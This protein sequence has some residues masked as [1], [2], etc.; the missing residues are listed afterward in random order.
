MPTSRIRSPNT[1]D[2]FINLTPDSRSVQTHSFDYA[3]P[4]PR[5]I[6]PPCIGSRSH[7]LLP[8]LRTF[9][10][11]DTIT[12]ADLTWRHPEDYTDQTTILTA[13]TVTH[14]HFCPFTCH[15]GHDEEHV[16]L[17][18]LWEYRDWFRRRYRPP[19][20]ATARNRVVAAF[21]GRTITQPEPQNEPPP[22]QRF[23]FTFV[24]DGWVERNNGSPPT[25]ESTDEVGTTSH[26]TRG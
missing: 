22:S 4:L 8:N 26:L 14:Y 13:L 3:V 16:L 12:V 21:R 1:T 24:L 9:L 2:P 11:N 5:P 23:S 6:D 10:S 7:D 17:L 25:N 19:F 20:S 18:Y 15:N